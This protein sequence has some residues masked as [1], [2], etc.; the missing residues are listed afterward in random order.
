MAPEPLD[1]DIAA[2]RAALD[3]IALPS[4]HRR[5]HRASLPTGMTSL[6]RVVADDSDVVGAFAARLQASPQ[7]LREAAAFYVEQ[8]LLAPSADSYRVLGAR[9]SA[10]AAELR[11]NLAF[12]CRWLHAEEHRDATRPALMLRVTHAWNNLKTP[13]R[14]AAYD[15]RSNARWPAPPRALRE[16][17]QDAIAGPGGEDGRLDPPKEPGTSR[18]SPGAAPRKR[19]RV[20]LWRRL[21]AFARRPRAS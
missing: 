17:W 11:E 15:A 16:A 12:L 14:R 4:R 18:R 6:L 19:K 1:P 2:M 13:E 7:R 9:R 21:L 3:L 8:V 5:F 20:G 10:T